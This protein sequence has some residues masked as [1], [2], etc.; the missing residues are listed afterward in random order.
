MATCCYM[1]SLKVPSTSADG[2][3][4]QM[5]AARRAFPADDGHRMEA[6][7]KEAHARQPRACGASTRDWW[8]YMC[9]CPATAD[10]RARLR[11]ALVGAKRAFIGDVAE[12]TWTSAWQST[13]GGP[14]DAAGER[15]LILAT[16]V[17]VATELE[18]RARGAAQKKLDLVHTAAAAVVVAGQAADRRASAAADSEYKAHEAA[19]SLFQNW[20][21]LA[22]RSG[23]RAARILASARMRVREAAAQGCGGRPYLPRALR[24]AILDACVTL[25]GLGTEGLQ[26]HGPSTWG[27]RSCCDARGTSA[28]SMRAT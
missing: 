18:G 17:G 5:V 19:R 28:G 27:S 24:R 23:P 14:R 1:V 13:G 6:A 21:R 22:A 20:A 7:K 4:L 15:D 3:L 12:P 16:A 9:H 11:A 8:H 25:T 26:A 2:I 10:E